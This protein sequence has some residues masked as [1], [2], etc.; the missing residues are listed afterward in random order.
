MRTMRA[1]RSLPFLCFDCL[2]YQV[3]SPTQKEAKRSTRRSAKH[4]VCP[5]DLA[6]VGRLEAEQPDRIAAENRGLLVLRQRRRAHHVIDR[7][8]LPRERMVAADNDLACADL[9]HKV[10]QRLA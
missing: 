1:S 5:Q 2:Q 10:A 7:M 6:R 9:R 3:P 4:R 8:P